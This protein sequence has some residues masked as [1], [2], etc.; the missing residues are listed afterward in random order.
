MLIFV[1][2]L[3]FLFINKTTIKIFYRCVDYFNL[4]S[5][6]KIL[7]LENRKYK[8]TL[9]MLENDPKFI[10]RIVK[11]ELGMVE[12]NEVVYVFNNE[13]VVNDEK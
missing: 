3:F 8:N 9:Y 4:K 1:L 2:V 11:S 6:F 7:E 5:E 12:E 10:Q 13:E